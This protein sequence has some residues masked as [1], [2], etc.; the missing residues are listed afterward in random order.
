MLT[1]DRN[2]TASIALEIAALRRAIDQKIQLEAWACGFIESI[3][4]SSRKSGQAATVNV[5]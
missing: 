3:A 4:M 5:S 2:P 1:G